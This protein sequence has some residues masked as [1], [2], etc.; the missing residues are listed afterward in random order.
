MDLTY[1][2]SS[3]RGY[4]LIRSTNPL[5]PGVD[6]YDLVRRTRNGTGPE[7]IVDDCLTCHLTRE[8][9]SESLIG[10]SNYLTFMLQCDR[11]LPRCLRCERLGRKVIMI[12][13]AA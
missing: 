10:K 5:A 4:P 9:A 6:R 7:G 11:N 2:S 12:R 8:E 3:S 13:E 1:S